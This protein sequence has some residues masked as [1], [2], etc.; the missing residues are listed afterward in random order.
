M[1]FRRQEE[2]LVHDGS[3]E[4]KKSSILLQVRLIYTIKVCK[5]LKGPIV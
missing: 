3:Y 5:L 4:V 2:Q 1:L